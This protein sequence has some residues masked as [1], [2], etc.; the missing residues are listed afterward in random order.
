MEPVNVDSKNNNYEMGLL[1]EINSL[2][3][4]LNSNIRSEAYSDCSMLI[5]ELKSYCFKHN[6]DFDKKYS[7]LI[8]RFRNIRDKL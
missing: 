6:I 4:Y 2:M 5:T 3:D 1:E 8:N 7:I